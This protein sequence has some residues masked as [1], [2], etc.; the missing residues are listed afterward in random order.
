MGLCE[1]G[2]DGAEIGED[3]SSNIDEPGLSASMIGTSTEVHQCL[4]IPVS[5]KDAN[6]NVKENISME[7]AAANGNDGGL[8]IS[9]DTAMEGSQSGLSLYTTEDKVVNDSVKVLWRGR[10]LR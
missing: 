8:T 1:R 10:F 7:L 6:P 4:M 2:T 9:S 3:I 5:S